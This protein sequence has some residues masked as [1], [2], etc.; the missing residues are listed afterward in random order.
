[1]KRIILCVTALICLMLFVS[2]SSESGTEKKLDATDYSVQETLNRCLESSLFP[3]PPIVYQN[4]S[5]KEL[6]AD[7]L[8]CYFGSS[9]LLE[10]VTGYVFITSPTTDVNEAGVFKVTT[11]SG[12]KALIK[13]FETRRDTLVQTHTNYSATDLQI[14]EN[15][16]IGYFDDVVYFIATP[17]NSVVE[18]L[19]KR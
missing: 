2:C 19:I 16:T 6:D 5:D 17:D 4:G 13:A 14:S 8:E 7:Y 10:D 12:R 11:E 3:G 15:M 18:S 9:S 1:M